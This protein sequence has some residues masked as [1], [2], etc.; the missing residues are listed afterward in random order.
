MVEVHQD[1]MVIS[2]SGGLM[3]GLDTRFLADI[4]VGGNE[5][6]TDMF[7]RMDKVERMET[8]ISRMRV[9]KSGGCPRA[10]IY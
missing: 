9:I 4:S 3:V 10:K 5:L 2:N 8:G 1:R 6:I 7:A